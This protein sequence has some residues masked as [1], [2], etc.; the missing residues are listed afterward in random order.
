MPEPKRKKKRMSNSSKSSPATIAAKIKAAKAL[1]L[2]KEGKTFDEIAQELGYRSKQTAHN[3]V[4]S[5]IKGI[6]REPAEELVRLDLERL[7][8]MWQVAY[9]N[10]CAGDASA[11]A[12]CMRIMDR[13]AKLLGLDAPPKQAE[14]DK[15][16]HAAGLGHFYG[17]QADAKPGA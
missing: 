12:S 1:E 14:Q 16:Q 13:R 15:E 17:Q 2:R 7:D 5:A 9:L 4:M 6:L 3:A 10:A 11:I 8:Q